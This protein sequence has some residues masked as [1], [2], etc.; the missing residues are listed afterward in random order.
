MK[1]MISFLIFM[2]LGCISNLPVAWA[3]VG[4][5]AWF[6]HEPYSSSPHQSA[7]V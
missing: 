1:S 7:D 6:Y 3:A 4:T 2:K 5:G